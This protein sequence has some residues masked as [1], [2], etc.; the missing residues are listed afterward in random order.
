MLHR[1]LVIG[2]ELVHSL[3]LKS[4]GGKNQRCHAWVAQKQPDRI[5]SDFGMLH[6]AHLASVHRRARAIRIALA[7]EQQHTVNQSAAN[8]LILI[9]P[10]RP[11][12]E[13]LILVSHH[14][15]RVCL[16]ARSVA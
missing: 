13:F 15:T 3:D 5:Q 7:A 4:E 2:S 16:D 12:D 1:S 10:K 14:D 9:E 11:S 6:E 8:E